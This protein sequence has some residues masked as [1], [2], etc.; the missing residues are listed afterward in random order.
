M[1]RHR[2]GAVVVTDSAGEV[3]GILSD[4][5]IVIG[6]SDLGVDVLG[7]S[8][9]DLMAGD[10]PSCAPDDTLQDV[11]AKLAGRRLGYVPVVKDGRAVGLLDVGRA[12][13]ARLDEKTAEGQVLLE[14]ARLRH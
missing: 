12:I 8:V 1:S 14:L 6:L 11:L 2:L 13:R 3:R 9:S 7:A 5:H 4:Q 10:V